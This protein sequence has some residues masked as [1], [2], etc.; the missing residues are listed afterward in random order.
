[1]SILTAVFAILC[2][3]LGLVTCGNALTKTR[4]FRDKVL[5]GAMSFAFIGL[6]MFFMVIVW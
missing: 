2:C 6:G 5:Y 3:F 4:D 1:M